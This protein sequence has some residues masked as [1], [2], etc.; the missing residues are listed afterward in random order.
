MKPFHVYMLRCRDGSYYVGHTDDIAVRI[1]QHQAGTFD[2]YTATRSPVELVF[3]AELETRI[4]ALEREMQLKGWSR[5]KK[6]A[7]ARGD[8]DAIRA[9]ARRG[10]RRQHV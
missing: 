4:E 6:A 9:L 5:A 2:G 1:A 7:L 3:S 8:W 10:A